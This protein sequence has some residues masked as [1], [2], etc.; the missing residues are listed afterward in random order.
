[1]PSR[2]AVTR[3]AEPAAAVLLR[4]PITGSA[5]CCARAAIGHAAA[6]PPSGAACCEGASLVPTANPRLRSPRHPAPNPSLADFD[7]EL[8]QSPVDGG[9][10][11][12]W[13][14]LAHA[15]DQSADFCAGL[16]SSRT[17]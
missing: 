12:Q 17:A 5:A 13:V 2:N 8:E 7:A 11:P 15:A 6:A 14:V 3:C 1:R 4:K 10:C 9:R 16:R